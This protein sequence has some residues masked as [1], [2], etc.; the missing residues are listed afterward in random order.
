V[1]VGV[2]LG[3]TVL[4]MLQVEVA[5]ASVRRM[6]LSSRGGAFKPLT[7]QE[8]ARVLLLKG[9]LTIGGLRVI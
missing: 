3:P 5:G 2:S 8:A 4:V 1:E 6:S 9:D 7:G